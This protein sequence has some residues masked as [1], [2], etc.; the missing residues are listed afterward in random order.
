M[1]CN[2]SSGGLR[3]HEAHRCRRVHELLLR[4]GGGDDN[5]LLV[6]DRLLSF[7]FLLYRLCRLWLLCDDRR[8]KREAG[9]HDAETHENSRRSAGVR[10][11]P[12]TGRALHAS[13]CAPVIQVT[14]GLHDMIRVLRP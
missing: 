7:L 5:L 14:Q 10:E 6:G 3:G 12:E 1:Y 4:S 2:T 13:H 9:G 8:S 11:T